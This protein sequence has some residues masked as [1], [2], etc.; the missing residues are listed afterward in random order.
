MRAALAAILGLLTVA[1]CN[2]NPLLSTAAS[3]YAPFKVGSSWS[4]QSPDGATSVLRTVLAVGPYSGR[5]AFTLSTSVNGGPGSLSYLAFADGELQQHSASLGWIISRR[6]PLVTNGKWSIPS[7]DPL[8][9]ITAVIDGYENVDVPAG[10]FGDCFRIRNRTE[11]YDSGSGTT[12]TAETL[13][14]AAPDVGDVQY[15]A[16]AADGSTAVTFVLVGYSIP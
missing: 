3:D 12:S 11:T 14:W 16:L 8:V 4:Y 10:H 6:L 7:G 9:S 13:A 5:E 1:G 15:G 2:A